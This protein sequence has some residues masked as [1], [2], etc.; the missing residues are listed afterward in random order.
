MLMK[1]TTLC[2]HVLVSGTYRCVDCNW[3]YLW[4]VVRTLLTKGMFDQLNVLYSLLATLFTVSKL[5]GE[6]IALLTNV[7]HV[8]V[9][10]DP[11]SRVG[12]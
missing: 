3:Y 5:L 7:R 1:C 8:N 2:G 6:Q 9:K 10:Q 4:L 11:G 12:I